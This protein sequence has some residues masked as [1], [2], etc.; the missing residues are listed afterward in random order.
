MNPITIT[1]NFGT[2]SETVEVD[3]NKTYRVEA[4]VDDFFAKGAITVTAK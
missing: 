2:H 4:I 3:R 1:A